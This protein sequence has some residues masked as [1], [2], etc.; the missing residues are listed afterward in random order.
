M[1]RGRVTAIAIVAA[2]AVACSRDP[3]TAKRSYLASG[4]QFFSQG[5]VKEAIVQ[6]LNA[7]R[8]D[9]R[10]GEARLKLADA[11][12]REGDTRRAVRQFIRAADLLPDNARAQMKAGEI[13]LLSGQFDDART[14]AKR[15]L[16]LEPENAEAHILIGNALLALNDPDTARAEIEEGIRLAPAGSHGFVSLGALEQAAGR[17]KE[18]ETAFK[19]AVQADPKSVAAHLA[20]A[21]FHWTSR[22]ATE[23]G[24]TLQ[25]AYSLDRDDPLVNRTLGLFQM[26]VGKPADAE[27]YFKTLA[28][29]SA[30]P[31]TKILLA[32]YYVASGRRQ[33]AVSILQE[34][35][36]DRKTRSAAELRLAELDFREG[37]HDRAQ[38]RISE[39]LDRE[40]NNATGLMLRAALLSAAGQRDAAVKQLQAAVR[41]S[42]GSAEAQFAL[43]R[44][45]LAT[46]D[47]DLARKAFNETLRLDPQGAAAQVELSRLELIGGRPDISVQY[48]E[49]AVKSAPESLE[50]RLAL[51]RALLARN[52]LRRAEGQLH[53]LIKEY[54]EVAAV[55]AQM[56][57]LAARKGNVAEATRSLTRALELD[58]NDLEA[59]TA[60]IAL[61]FS[62]KNPA[63][64][65]ARAEERLARTPNDPGALLL[66]ASTY[67]SAGDLQKS[68]QALRKTIELDPSNLQGYGMLGRLY[69]SQQRLDEALK[70]FDEAARQQPRPVQAHTV[71]G[72]IL[73]VQNKPLE[74]R[75]RYEMALAIDPE[76]PVAANNLAWMYAESG[77]NLDVALQLALSAS[78]R[79]P[80]HPAIQD[81]LGWIYYKRGLPALA[82]EPFRKSI[83]RDPNNP[84]YR[85]HLGLA[86]AKLGD[87]PNARQALQQA[88]TLG[89]N[90]DGAAEARKVLASLEG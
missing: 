84:V 89:N 18:A 4:D 45:Y 9:P 59:L 87:S 56:G 76:A 67:A 29:V 71:A 78:R 3:E 34:L 52:D 73:E 61:D 14:R 22:R 11:Y 5:K 49:Q 19:K 60:L 20:L 27:P 79:M 15:A 65:V 21:N 36:S 68:E 47:P 28:R 51:V 75:K 77:G 86:Y 62:R 41:A 39:L 12:V 81:T 74:A 31:N 26:A 7:L 38:K 55:Q 32:D 23:T 33:E 2:L 42:P 43:G 82:V 48:A 70:E 50:A 30:D 6:Y 54:S 46:N 88:L 85:F 25:Q 16:D 90:F 35:T 1:N 64:A 13:L 57:F 53:R 44:A 80:D 63:G 24:R 8:Q 37:N 17:R 69:L 10:Y 83:D 66:A 72:V 58:P 40:P